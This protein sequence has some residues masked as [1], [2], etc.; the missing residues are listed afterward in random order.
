MLSN[1]ACYSV[2]SLSV[3]LYCKFCIFHLLDSKSDGLLAGSA[4]RNSSPA[5]SCT[6]RSCIIKSRSNS[7]S[8]S[9]SSNSEQ[10]VPFISNHPSDMKTLVTLTSLQLSSLLLHYFTAAAMSAD[11]RE[12]TTA[13]G[14]S[15]VSSRHSSTKS[16]LITD[17]ISNSS[18]SSSSKNYTVAD[19]WH[20]NGDHSLSQHHDNISQLVFKTTSDPSTI[21]TDARRPSSQAHNDNPMA[22]DSGNHSNQWLTTSTSPVASTKT[23]ESADSETGVDVLLKNSN[24]VTLLD[25]IMTSE[26]TTSSQTV[27]VDPD[28]E[29]KDKVRGMQVG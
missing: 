24:E 12:S 22:T 14:E 18:S 16:W 25:V 19:S 6:P 10:T 7:S 1:L 20:S 21:A 27:R 28:L 5:D 11:N 8:R 15:D 23:R 29:H 9:S 17:F 2:L 13:S 4:A 3:R 26:V